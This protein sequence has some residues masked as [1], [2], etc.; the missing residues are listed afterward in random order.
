MF[1]MILS[2]NKKVEDKLKIDE[3]HPPLFLTLSPY[4]SD[5]QFYSESKKLI[6]N[7]KLEK[8]K[9]VLRINNKNYFLNVAKYK[10]SINLSYSKNEEVSY[11][12]LNYELSDNLNN[13]YKKT[14]IDIKSVLDKKYIQNER[15]MPLIVSYPL[16]NLIYT[17]YKD[18]DKYILFGYKLI[19]NKSGN[20]SE[21]QQELDEFS[22][23]MGRKSKT[24]NSMF[25]RLSSN[26]PKIT[27]GIKIKIDYFERGY[28]DSLLDEIYKV[29]KES[30]LKEQNIRVLKEKKNLKRKENLNNI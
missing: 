30:E 5:N 14:L 23:Q 4:M 12:S 22:R 9:F 28:M 29:N 7:N 24:D 3:F 15:Q 11:S 16:D 6:K 10:H 2:C 25:T 20:K 8:G 19:T 1:S 27:F 18:K 17:L 13:K 21:R 26:D